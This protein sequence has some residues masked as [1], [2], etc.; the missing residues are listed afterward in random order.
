[1]KT[2][3]GICG[4]IIAEVFPKQ[5]I[6]IFGAAN[7]STY[8]TDFAIRSF[9][10]YLCMMIPACI[11][12]AAFIYLQAMG[13]A[14]ISTILSLLRELVF[15]VGLA[16]ILPLWFGLDG[17]LYS[18]PAADIIAFVFSLTVILHTF[19]SLAEDQVQEALA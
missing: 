6:S 13:K 12:K 16:L 11:N 2:C 18:M 8:Y 4:L 1:V 7:E 17:V 5:L 14:L 10:I 19:H 15:G 3:V 9:R